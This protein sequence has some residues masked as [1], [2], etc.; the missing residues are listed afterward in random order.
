MTRMIRYVKA[1]VSVLLCFALASCGSV[2]NA[3]KEQQ[4]PQTDK[5][6]AAANIDSG[7]DT[8]DVSLKHMPFYEQSGYAGEVSGGI[9]DTYEIDDEND[10]AD[11]NEIILSPMND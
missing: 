8:D 4:V 11:D 6:A 3:G 7:S 10:A 2:K 1:A 9:C 5:P